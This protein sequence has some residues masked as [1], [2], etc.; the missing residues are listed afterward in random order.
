MPE[1]KGDPE[2]VAAAEKFFARIGA[3]EAAQF[4]QLP[5]IGEYI[6]ND[7]TAAGHPEYYDTLIKALRGELKPKPDAG[8]KKTKNR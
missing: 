5:E 6:K 4:F 3:P 2:F 1:T 7:F 8:R